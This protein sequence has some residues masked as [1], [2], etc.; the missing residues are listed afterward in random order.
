MRLNSMRSLRDD[1]K[2]TTGLQAYDRMA[3]GPLSPCR[4]RDVLDDYGSQVA[5]D[6]V[7]QAR[8]DA[9]VGAPCVDLLVEYGQAAAVVVQGNAVVARPS[10]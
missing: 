7:A 3:I 2:V 10:P 6:L 4:T 5:T 9:G 1:V 8:A